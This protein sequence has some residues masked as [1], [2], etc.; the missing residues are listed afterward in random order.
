MSRRVV[1]ALLHVSLRRVRSTRF[2]RV[3]KW[4]GGVPCVAPRTQRLLSTVL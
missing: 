3:T 1:S 4:R 2:E